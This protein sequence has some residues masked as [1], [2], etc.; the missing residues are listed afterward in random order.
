MNSLRHILFIIIMA[1]FSLRL[2][3]ITVDEAY[4]GGSKIPQFTDKKTIATAEDGKSI[5]IKQFSPEFRKG[6]DEATRYV[7]LC[8]HEDQMLYEFQHDSDFLKNSGYTEFSLTKLREFEHVTLYE[9]IFGFKDSK[10]SKSDINSFNTSK[11]RDDFLMKRLVWLDKDGDKYCRA[12]YYDPSAFLSAVV[13]GK[14]LAEDYYL[15]VRDL[16]IYLLNDEL[17]R[18][19]AILD[20]NDSLDILS[21]LGMPVHILRTMQSFDKDIYEGY[22]ERYSA[23]SERDKVVR[24]FNANAAL[25]EKY[26]SVPYGLEKYE[27][28]TVKNST[29]KPKMT[30]SI[31]INEAE[32]S[33]YIA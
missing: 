32:L 31:P 2:L 16:Y 13:D 7:I 4:G 17:D 27:V 15:H 6:Y 14:N 28:Q 29:F 30:G 19:E 5:I 11:E 9:F 20:N 21:W 26:Y 18:A 22:K 10:F 23:L 12:L 25:L 8:E 3:C 1:L 33:E 24:S